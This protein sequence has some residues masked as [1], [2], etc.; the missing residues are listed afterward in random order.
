M[1]FLRLVCARNIRALERNSKIPQCESCHVIALTC[2]QP[3]SN[4]FYHPLLLC[5][6]IN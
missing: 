6:P 1:N 2:V 4:Y 3:G 5:E